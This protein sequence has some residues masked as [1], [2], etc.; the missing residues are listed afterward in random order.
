[1][2]ILD[3]QASLTDCPFN[4]Y[5]AHKQYKAQQIFDRR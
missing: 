5:F 4:K 3:F 2:E 1:M